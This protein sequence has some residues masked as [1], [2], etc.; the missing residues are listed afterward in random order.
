LPG[1]RA[2]PST[3][4]HATPPLPLYGGGKQRIESDAGV[5]GKLASI[6]D[7]HVLPPLND[8]RAVWTTPFFAPGAAL[9]TAA[10]PGA[11]LVVAEGGGGGGIKL[12]APGSSATVRDGQKDIYACKVRPSLSGQ[13]GCM[14]SVCLYQIKGAG[15]GQRLR[16]PMQMAACWGLLS[17]RSFL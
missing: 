7:L 15:G 16:P 14:P 8:T 12:Q 5:R 17:G 3:P 9:P 4:P 10:G 6:M 2:H 13:A 1:P 11:P